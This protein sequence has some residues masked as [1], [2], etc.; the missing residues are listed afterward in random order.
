MVIDPKLALDHAGKRYFAFLRN[1]DAGVIVLARV[2]DGQLRSDDDYEVVLPDEDSCTRDAA[3]WQRTGGTVT[4]RAAFNAMNNAL[5]ACNWARHAGLDPDEARDRQM[6]VEA[7][8]ALQADVYVTDNAFALTQTPTGN[9]FACT[10]D[11]ALAIIGL[12]QRLQGRIAVDTDS[13]PTT[14]DLPW[15]EYIQAWA[16]LPNTLNL[17]ALRANQ[18]GQ[19][20]DHWKD[21]ARVGRTRV[22]RCL[23]SRD[24]I[25]VQS[26]HPNLALP[27]DTVDALVERVA[28]NLSGMFDALARAINAALSLGREERSCSF[29]RGDFKQALLPLLQQPVG[30]DRHKALLGVISV[31]R[32]T[33]HHIALSGASA[34]DSRGPV[35]ES[36]VLLPA[37]EAQK[38]RR[39]ATTLNTTPRWIASDFD[40]IGL[41]L[42]P[43]QLIE[44]LIDESIPLFEEL[45]SKTEWPG[46][47]DE[48]PGIRRDDPGEYWMYYTPTVS[49]VSRLYGLKPR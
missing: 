11:E 34:G 14:L 43:V 18:P 13:I 21:L 2:L 10:A 27:F 39:H 30:T 15:A 17:F 47:V 9:V 8:I 25:L 38:F 7:A 35:S 32:N 22:E 28:L 40:E 24:Q 6:D 3:V 29:T 16:L 37:S 45:I 12:H 19:D 41:L 23:R 36:Y 1:G 49:L 42:R 20:T 5:A 48:T 33:I 46:T 4:W 44:D 26:I 31:L